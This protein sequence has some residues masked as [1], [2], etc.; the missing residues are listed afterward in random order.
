MRENLELNIQNINLN[1]KRFYEEAD[2]SR[3]IV[4]EQLKNVQKKQQELK[5]KEDKLNHQKN[6]QKTFGDAKSSKGNNM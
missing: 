2:K 1:F 4:T 6:Q 5:N 3:K